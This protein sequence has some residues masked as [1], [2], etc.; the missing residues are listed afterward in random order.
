MKILSATPALERI[1]VSR[2]V[3]GWRFAM[4][5]DVNS[6]GIDSGRQQLVADKLDTLCREFEV[7]I[8]ITAF[9]CETIKLHLERLSFQPRR[10]QVR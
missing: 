8:G 4:C 3:L 1:A 2:I 10:Q 7:V 9:V 6:R 5:R